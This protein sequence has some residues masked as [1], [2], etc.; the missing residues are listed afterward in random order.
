MD[1]QENYL[2]IEIINELFIIKT[3]DI[4]SLDEIKEKAIN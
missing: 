2:T 3:K 1:E 4:I